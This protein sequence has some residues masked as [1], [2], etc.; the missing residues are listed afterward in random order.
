MDLSGQLIKGTG[1]YEVKEVSVESG[2]LLLKGTG[3]LTTGGWSK[4]GNTYVLDYDTSVSYLNVLNILT[5]G[6]RYRVKYH[7]SA[8]PDNIGL[9]F[10]TLNFFTQLSASSHVGMNEYEAV[11]ITDDFYLRSRASDGESGLVIDYISLEEVPEG[12]PLL[13]KGSKY[14]EC[15]S[16][17]LIAIPSD[18]AY[19]EWEFSFCKFGDANAVS[20]YV[21][22]NE[23]GYF[24][25]PTINGYIVYSGGSEQVNIDRVNGS[26]SLVTVRGGGNGSSELGAWHRLKV[27]RTLDGVWTLQIKGGS[28]GTDDWTTLAVS[29]AGIDNTYKK[30][31]YIVVDLDTGDRIA[32]LEMRNIV[33]Q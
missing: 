10:D 32:N 1:A 30:S 19:G 24:V 4:V 25:S 6:K 31:K 12:Y 5:I 33:R 15:T 20:V 27:T 21:I 11:A 17:G 9:R 28:Y 3:L 7:I 8:N 14:L 23:V 16:T 26:S 2:N 22:S 29:G 13:D 18:Q